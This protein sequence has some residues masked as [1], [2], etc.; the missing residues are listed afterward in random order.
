LLGGILPPSPPTLENYA[1]AKRLP[2]DFLESL[3]LATVHVQGSPAVK[4]PYFDVEGADLG[5]RFRVALDGK[6]RLKWR[7]GAR[8]LPYGPWRLDRSLG[9]VILCEG[10]IRYET[11][12]KIRQGLQ[13][14]LIERA[15][16]TGLIVT[17][18]GPTCTPRT[19]SGCC[20]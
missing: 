16:P 4:M 15:G 17:T 10:E 19:R 7:K 6:H 2:V 13:P 5:A 11:V 18:T 3:G 12:E 8:V 14:R 20:R 9:S 1:A